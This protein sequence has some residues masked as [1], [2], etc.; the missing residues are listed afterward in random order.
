[1][2]LI[3]VF[4]TVITA[5]PKSSSGQVLKGVVWEVPEILPEAIRDLREMKDSGVQVVRIG[6][7]PDPIL[8]AEADS[9]GLVFYRDMPL[10]DVPVR[11]LSDSLAMA[12]RTL[13]EMLISGQG[14]PSAGPIG[15][16]INTDVTNTDACSYF[17]AVRA[18]S[19]TTDQK[20]YYV[21]KFVESDVCHE[22]V[23]FVLLDAVDKENPTEIISRWVGDRS[24]PVAITFG[25][26]VEQAYGD[27]LQVPFSVE[28]QARFY[29]T[30]LTTLLDSGLPASDRLVAVFAHRWRDQDGDQY[31]RRFGI[32]GDDDRRLSKNVLR[33]F[34]TG[35]QRVFA[36]A[37]TSDPASPDIWY[38][39]LGWILIGIV[40]ALYTTSPRFR[41]MAP[42][43]FIAHGFYR[44]AVR[45]A[46]E[47]LPIVSTALLTVVGLATGM[48][49]TQMLLAVH[50][51]SSFQYLVQLSPEMIQS[52]ISVLIYNPLVATFFLGS[53]A[54][55]G[56]T[57][58]MGLW[59]IV[60]GQRPPLLPSQALMLAVW[61]RW[62]LLV[63]LPVSMAIATLEPGMVQVGMY[64]LFPVWVG[65]GLWAAGRTSY[66]IYK[67][68]N[69]SIWIAAT[70]LAL[71]P[72]VLITMGTV[73]ALLF[74]GDHVSFML[75]LAFRS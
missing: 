38:T 30:S 54:L 36:F 75:H 48:I 40:A 25:R 34:Y 71:H 2:L 46:R 65:V 24:T 50:D 7:I 26:R 66:D 5:S 60:A 20:Y 51:T 21:S 56:L 28:S 27:G 3:T 42:R 15:L 9:L 53:M 23:D 57:L 14:H 45:E 49:A 31:G 68:T 62:Q 18:S 37:N 32:E 67:L 64:A 63:L 16:V 44:N 17:D 6:A 1:M 58:W 33:G 10:A 74:Q 59:M 13:S 12:T 4:A 8:F 41:D 19:G 72:A 55:L 39:V 22:H 11:L 73:I 70:G 61:P 47:V 35:E 69:C 43:Y 52:T 29:E